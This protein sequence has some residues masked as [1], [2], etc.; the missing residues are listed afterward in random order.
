MPCPATPRVPA[1]GTPTMDGGTRVA[2]ASCYLWRLHERKDTFVHGRGTLYGYP[3]AA[4]GLFVER[5]GT[6]YYDK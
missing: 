3:G 1:R 6:V 4:W 2:G 5:Q